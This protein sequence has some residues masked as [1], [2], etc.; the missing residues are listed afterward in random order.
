MKDTGPKS[1]SS[2]DR[3]S[4]EREAVEWHERLSGDTNTKTEQAF[5]DW[6]AI[7]QEHRQVYLEAE[8]LADDFAQLATQPDLVEHLT[9][10]SDVD[11]QS[12]LNV[13]PINKNTKPVKW[14]VSAMAV[15][16]CLAMVTIVNTGW[17]DNQDESSQFVAAKTFQSQYHSEIGE[18]KKVELPDGSRLTLGPNSLINI[19]FS[20][21]SRKVELVLGEAYFDVAKSPGR[22]FFVEADQTSVK[23]VGTRFDVRRLAQMTSVSVVEGVVQVFNGK[24]S[25][26]LASSSLLPTTLL[27][28]QYAKSDGRSDIVMQKALVSQD[29]VAWLDG[30]L[31]YNGAELRDVLADANRY[32]KSG[33]IRLNDQALGEKKV[34]LSVNVD[35]ISDLPF[36]LVKLMDLD[37]SQSANETVL[38]IKQ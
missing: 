30:R 26:R 17:F 15:A 3:M 10:R 28:G 5:D 31:V 34:T 9:M 8:L 19:S 6:M 16:A 23:V 24:E 38:S 25:A 32:S 29:L 37:I 18:L 2:L 7:S 33:I 35:S 11:D 20:E 27:A 13:V 14:L 12:S 36:M 21:L 1:L 22:P 4:I